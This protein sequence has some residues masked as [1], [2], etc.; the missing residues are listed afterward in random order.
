MP[1]RALIALS[2]S[3]L[4]IHCC[5]VHLPLFAQEPYVV[6]VA[7]AAWQREPGTPQT[8]AR[9]DAGLVLVSVV[10]RDAKG[11]VVGKL[12]QENFLLFDQGKPQTIKYF[13]AESPT[14]DDRDAAAVTDVPGARHPVS[15]QSGPAAAGRATAYLFDDVHLHLELANARDAAARHIRSLKTGERAAIFS[16][17]HTLS[18]DFT[19]DRD[20]LLAGLRTLNPPTTSAAQSPC[21]SISYYMADLMLNQLDPFAQGVAAAEAAHCGFPAI[22]ASATAR[23]VLEAGKLENKNSL[24]TLKNVIRRTETMPGQRSVVLVSPGFLANT[25]DLHEDVAEIIDYAVRSGVIVHTLDARGAYA[26]GTTGGTMQGIDRLQIDGAEFRAD[27][28]LLVEFAGGTGGIFF[29][30][31]N[32][33]D[34][35]FRRTAAVPEFVYVLGFTPKKLDDKFHKL[36][37][38]LS[39]AEKLNVQAR[40]GY[41]ALKAK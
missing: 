24:A 5:L 23:D 26:L 15:L 36:K 32:D 8:P 29:G 31:D 1:R 37:V 16:T 40:P 9:A 34:E 27:D 30:G 18:V 3:L 6:P 28:D 21:P 22:W 14:N 11:N 12:S 19:D 41:Y 2:S 39:G 13:S 20:K 17:S 4:L 33:L 38:T 25:R 35:G 10:P 7:A